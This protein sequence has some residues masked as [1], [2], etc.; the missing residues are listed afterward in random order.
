MSQDGIG[1]FFH[2]FHWAPP[3]ARHPLLSDV[4]C[5]S[6]GWRA[7]HRP[8][9][10][11]FSEIAHPEAASV[12]HR[13]GPTRGNFFLFHRPR[14]ARALGFDASKAQDWLGAA[15][16]DRIFCVVDRRTLWRYVHL[17]WRWPHRHLEQPLDL[18]ALHAALTPA[19]HWA[20]EGDTLPP[21]GDKPT[22]LKPAPSAAP[23]A[24]QVRVP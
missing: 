3:C 18:L 22:N 14:E 19:R 13:E 24:V 8:L 10:R 17:N 2:C 21:A 9:P 12:V 15:V 23:L 4:G 11:G 7:N 20:A 16:T 5:S 6:P 1:A